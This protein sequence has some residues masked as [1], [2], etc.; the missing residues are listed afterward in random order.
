[1][2]VQRGVPASS[3][4]K[5]EERSPIDIALGAEIKRVR[6][7]TGL[8]QQE[9][10]DRYGVARHNWVR[11]ETGV[12]ELTPAKLT[13]IAQVLGAELLIRFIL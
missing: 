9:C 12:V 6:Q 11:Y 7:L 3:Y 2:R 13:R 8:S 5:P 10:A 4:R 1:M